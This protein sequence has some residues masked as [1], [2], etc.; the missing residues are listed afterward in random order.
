MRGPGGARIHWGH[1]PEVTDGHLSTPQC[2]VSYFL[3]MWVTP[4][5]SQP[6]PLHTEKVPQTISPLAPKLTEQNLP[7]AHCETATGDGRGGCE[8]GILLKK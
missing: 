4:S 2:L 7:S 8:E 6:I 3:N 1:L 5:P